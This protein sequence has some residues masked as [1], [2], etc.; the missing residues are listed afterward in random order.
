MEGPT[1]AEV[2]AITWWHPFTFPN[3]VKARGTKGGDRSE[4]IVR[5]EAQIAFK[6]PVQG[7]TVLDVEHRTA[8]LA[9][10]PYGRER[11]GLSHLMS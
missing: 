3:G 10:K 1:Q 11:R 6:Y 2:D 9:L 4:E 8:T 7:K 5:A